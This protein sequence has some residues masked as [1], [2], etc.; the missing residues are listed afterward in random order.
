MEVEVHAEVAA[1]LSVHDLHGTAAV[2]R[3]Y[4]VDGTDYLTSDRTLRLLEV[5][6]RIEVLQSTI[7]QHEPTLYPC[8][9]V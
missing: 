5:E 8:M 9:P 4:D 2:V 1:T 6:F 3:L 7:E